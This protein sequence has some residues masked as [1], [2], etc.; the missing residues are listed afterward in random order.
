MKSQERIS[1]QIS[2]HHHNHHYYLQPS[3]C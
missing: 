2:Y 1:Q 3:L